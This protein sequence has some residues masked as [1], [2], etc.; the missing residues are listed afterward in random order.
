MFFQKDVLQVKDA[1][2]HHLLTRCQPFPDF[3]PTP[4]FAAD[5]YR[6]E[7]IPSLP[8]YEDSARLVH[9]RHC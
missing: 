5:F 1:V 6:D 8:L 7:C 9:R 4:A 2:D 3:N